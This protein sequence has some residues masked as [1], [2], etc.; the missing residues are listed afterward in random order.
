[1]DVGLGSAPG[2]TT[3]VPTVVQ[4]AQ[5]SGAFAAIKKADGNERD[6]VI[7]AGGGTTAAAAAAVAGGADA[8]AAAAAAAAVAAAANVQR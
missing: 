1:M 8:A 6:M 5:D 4:R 2:T 3:A 7:A